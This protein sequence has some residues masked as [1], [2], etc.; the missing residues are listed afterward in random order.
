MKL[1][2]AL[3][4]EQEDFILSD[5][6]YSRKQLE[7]DLIQ[8]K[9]WLAEQHHLPSSRLKEKDCFLKTYLIGCKGSMEKAKR[10]LDA[11]YTYR[12]CSDLFLDRDP[13]LAEY[14]RVNE[15][16][17]IGLLP[18]LS[19]S[20]DL[21][22]VYKPLCEDSKNYDYLGS[23]RRLIQ[24]TELKMRMPEVV[25]GSICYLV[26]T[27][28]LTPSHVLM[29]TP[30][31]VRDM[32]HLAQKVMPFRLKEIIFVNAPFFVE[33]SINKLVKPFLSNKMKDRLHVFSSGHEE[34]LKF[35]DRS[36]LPEELGGEDPAKLH[37]LTKAW[38]EKAVNERDWF[39]NELSERNDESKRINQ[40]YSMS[41]DLM[42]GE[43]TSLRLLHNLYCYYLYIVI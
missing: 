38:A 31:I 30:T 40:D 34:F 28:H 17:N 9:D 24:I 26:D 35:I 4:T 22:M 5:V 29:C 18:K 41:S 27:K 2:E 42:F 37:D 23:M 1:L 33:I 20:R 13:L 39:L 6:G 3:T 7:A 36:I 25:T 14:K 21:V 11:Y 19:K 16:I 43:F 32:L 12:S 8:L 10:K 15:Y